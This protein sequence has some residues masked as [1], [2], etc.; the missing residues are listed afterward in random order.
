MADEE[1]GLNKAELR[2][3]YKAL[4]NMQEGATEAAKRDAA[5]ISEYARSSIIDSAALRMHGQAVALRIATGAKV[6][7]SSKTGEITYGFAAQKFSGGGTT[8][9]LW[10]GAEFGSN[11]YKQFPVWSGR[12]GR[13]SRGWFIYPTLRKI[14]PEIVAKWNQSFTN[15]L[16]EWG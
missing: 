7:Y 15:I 16:K 1:V 12:Y 10:G 8:K 9:E 11:K 13:G 4:K 2:A 5:S 14:Q 6:K 3:V